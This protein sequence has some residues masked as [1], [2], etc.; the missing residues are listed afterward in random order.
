MLII[1]S[2]QIIACTYF[3]RSLCYLFTLLIA[4]LA[5]QLFSL[6]KSHLSVFCSFPVLWGSCPKT[7][8]NVGYMHS[9]VLK[10]CSMISSVVSHATFKSLIHFKMFFATN[11]R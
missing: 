9:T 11:E 2:C 1:N 3:P 8:C 10:M 6:M 5:V 7:P 4:S